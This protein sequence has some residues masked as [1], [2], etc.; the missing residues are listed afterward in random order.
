MSD[1]YLLKVRLNKD[2]RKALEFLCRGVNAKE[3]DIVRSLIATA[4]NELFEEI[5]RRAT[6]E[7]A[8]L[9]PAEVPSAPAE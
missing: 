7:P 4:A 2:Y 6:S 3:A 1:R 5:K 9:P 8:A